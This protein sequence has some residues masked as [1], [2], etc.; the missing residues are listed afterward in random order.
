VKIKVAYIY[1][2]SFRLD[3]EGVYTNWLSSCAAYHKLSSLDLTY[4]FM[5]D[6]DLLKLNKDFLQHDTLTDILTFDDSIG[7][8]INANIAISIDRV[9][10]NANDFGVSFA[11]ELLRVMAHGLLHCVG[12]GDSNVADKTQ[13]RFEEDALIHLFHVEHKK[14]NHV[15]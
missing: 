4:A 6:D 15:S 11:D 14:H 13:M 10:E 9:R 8:D 1:E 3:D 2:T 5:G 7:K 12:Y